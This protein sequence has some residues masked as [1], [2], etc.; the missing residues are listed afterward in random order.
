M[1]EKSAAHPG[2]G[3]E[4]QPNNGTTDKSRI[5]IANGEHTRENPNVKEELLGTQGPKSEMV[6]VGAHSSPKKRRKVNHGK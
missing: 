1:T 6:A 2:T 3:P 5:S 4:H